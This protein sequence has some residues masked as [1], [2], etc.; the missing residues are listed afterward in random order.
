MR[1]EIYSLFWYRLERRQCAVCYTTRLQS[2]Y[3]NNHPSGFLHPFRTPS[4]N[5]VD[6]STAKLEDSA[7]HAGS[8]FFRDALFTQENL[9]ARGVFVVLDR[10]SPP[11]GLGDFFF[12]VL[13]LCLGKKRTGSVAEKP[14]PPNQTSATGDEGGSDRK[15]ARREK[16]TPTPITTARS[17]DAS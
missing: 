12:W 14:L 2:F 7:L 11:P 5:W 17:K 4:L 15:V 8:W 10:G 3:K 1:R 9:S 13:R 16:N 6:Y